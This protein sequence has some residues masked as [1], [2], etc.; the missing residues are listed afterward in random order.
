M[1]S[2]VVPA[3]NEEGNLRI[4]CA[5]LQVILPQFAE[6]WEIVIAD[7]G[8]T[9]GTWEEI[10]EL[11]AAEPRI[12]GLRLSRNF[13]HQNAL[14]AGL[15][16]SKGDAVVSMDADLQHPP[17][18]VQTLVQKWREGYEVV[19]TIRRDGVPISALKR[20]TSTAFYRV[21][22]Y[23]SGVTLTPGMAD[24]RLLDRRVLDQL[25]QFR[26]EG[27]FLRG[28]VHWVG[29]ATTSITY[30]SA[31]RHSGTTKYTPRRMLKLAWHGISSF[32]L[33][34]LR[35]GIVLGLMSST[36]AFFGVLYAIIGKWLSGEVVQGWAS[37]VAINSFLF[38]V[39]FV[40][41]A[42]L[43][44]YVGRILVE[45]RQ[46]PRFLIRD[47]TPPLAQKTTRENRTG[48]SP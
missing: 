43:A 30:E 32:S 29:Y 16:A 27:L 35:I 33:V 21:F 41:L 14:F 5:K 45:V 40:F 44:E 34:P 10:A 47:T 42:I 25:L 26:E 9:D 2:I 36:L 48:V 19:H 46:R 13:G 8:S 12:R 38:G 22:S 24:F 3:H 4:L 7:D 31:Q 15:A 20:R 23:L 28:L 17:E 11:N 37:S 18:T 39:L 6:P 1:I